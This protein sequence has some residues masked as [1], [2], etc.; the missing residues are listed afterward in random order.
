MIHNSE[1]GVAGLRVAT[2]RCNKVKWKRTQ[3][4][5]RDNLELYGVKSLPIEIATPDPG[6]IA[7]QA[8]CPTASASRADQLRRPIQQTNILR[9]PKVI[10]FFDD[11]AIPV[12]K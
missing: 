9:A 7:N 12:K 10:D 11:Y 4:E 2:A 5:A 8:D 3:I 6:L 1:K